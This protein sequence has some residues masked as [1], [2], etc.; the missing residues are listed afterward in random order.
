MSPDSTVSLDPVRRSPVHRHHVALGATF[1]REA[2]WELPDGYGDPERERRILREGLGIADISASEKVD[3]RGAIE[4]ALRALTGTVPAVGSIRAVVPSK[5]GTSVA[6]VGR[7]WALVVGPPALGDGRLAEVTAATAGS[8]AMATDATGLYSGFVLAGAA[9][10]E[11]LSRLTAFDLSQ[12]GPGTCA[13]TRVVEI[14]GILLRRS[15]WEGVIEL[16]VG[17]EYGRYAWETVLS[18]GRP[19]GVM[20]VGWRALRA[21]GWW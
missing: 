8:P 12:L 20:P 7:S 3:I 6:R 17:S 5:G 13:A 2:G 1:S 15:G 21:E 14:P 11:L 18:V 19:L 9:C 10:T 4:D 16:Y